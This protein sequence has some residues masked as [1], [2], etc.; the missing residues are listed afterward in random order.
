MKQTLIALLIMSGFCWGCAML[1]SWKAIPPPG[2]CDQC[3]TRPINAN[4]QIA[5]KAVTLNDETGKAAWQKPESI[6]P[7]EPSPMEQKKVTE[8]RCFRCHKGPDKSH[9]EYRGRYHH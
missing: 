2:G 3:H 9:T 5:Y 1:G 4:W 6:L 7:P 8:Q